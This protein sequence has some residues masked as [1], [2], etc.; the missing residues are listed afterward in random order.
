M[1][2]WI[3]TLMCLGLFSSTG[4]ARIIDLNHGK[5]VSLGDLA[6]EGPIFVVGEQHYTDEIQKAT[7]K[8]IAGIVR[9]QKN[10]NSFDFGW[11]FLNIDQKEQVN[12]ALKRYWNKETS[13]KEALGELL[14]P[15]EGNQSYGVVLEAIRRLNGSVIPL[16]LSRS[17]KSQVSQGGMEALDPEWLP[18]DFA[19]G[20][21]SYY[22]RFLDAMGGHGGAQVDNYFAA[23]SLVDNTMAKELLAER[24]FPLSFLL[25]GS[26]HS[27]YRHGV[28]EEL[29]R[30]SPFN[31]TVITF[32]SDHGQTTAEIISE[33][34]DE[35]YGLRADFA[36]AVKS[37]N[38]LNPEL[39]TQ[40]VSHD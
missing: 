34:Q 30:R 29:E 4:M 12:M 17:I 18:Q 26:F 6:S 19:L 35:R 21:L 40:E 23:Q 8:L 32:V 24:Q 15:Y 39:L 38:Q 31:P 33:L 36:V 27:D 5:E 16:N 28:V 22:E 25:C 9:S 14:G 13:T 7:A 20:S 1:S 37:N 2:R 3:V 10:Q 11:E